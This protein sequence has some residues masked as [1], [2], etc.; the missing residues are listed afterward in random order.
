MVYLAKDRR[1]QDMCRA[2]AA[3]RFDFALS[4]GCVFSMKNIPQGPKPDLLF[5]L[6]AGRRKSCRFA[7][8]P[9]RLTT[10][11]AP[12]QGAQMRRAHSIPTSFP[13]EKMKRGL[14]V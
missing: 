8:A 9:M 14:Y 7:T 1:S 12:L 4:S 2:V 6:F 5:G 10:D 11:A 3:R 13:S